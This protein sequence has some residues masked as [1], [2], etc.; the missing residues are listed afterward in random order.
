MLL[1]IIRHG[2]TDLNRRGCVQGLIDEPLNEKGIELTRLTG[3]GLADVFFDYAISS[4]LG[5][6]KQTADIIFS[7]NQRPAPTVELDSRICEI[8]WGSWDA[9]CCTADNNELPVPRE[10]YFRMYSDPFHF[11]G[12]PDGES[13]QDVCDRTKLFFDDLINRDDLQE[14]TILISTHACAVR[15]ILHNIYEDKTDFW[16]GRVPYNCS[17]SI[18]EVDHGKCRLI[19]ED[20]VFYEIGHNSNPYDTILQSVGK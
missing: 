16:H 17:V 11:D 3:K 19:A 18:V 10:E 7:E 1:Y 9:L 6:A 5:R 8:N 15:G 20:K 13:I 4:P 2:E 12:A 14:K